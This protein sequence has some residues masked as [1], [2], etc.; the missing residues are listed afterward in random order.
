MIGAG[1]GPSNQHVRML[2]FRH[3]GFD[4]AWSGPPR[5]GGNTFSVWSAASAD[6]DIPSS[7][8]I[9]LRSR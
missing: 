9:R 8:P 6:R 1:D 2:A 4:V 5:Y 3:T 7:H